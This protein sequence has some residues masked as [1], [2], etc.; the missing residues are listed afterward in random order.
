[1]SKFTGK[2]RDS[3]SGLDNFG[4]RYDSSSLGRF[5][6]V[7]PSR[8]SINPTNPQSWNRYTYTLNNPL[9]LVDQNG[10]WPTRIHDEIIE[11]VFGGVLTRH[12]V[13]LLKQVSAG[14]DSIRN[15]GPNPNNSNWHGQCTPSQSTTQC[16]AGISTYVNGNLAIAWVQADL[17]GLTD[18][19]LTYF[20]KAGHTLTDLGSPSHVAADGTPTTWYG[21][22]PWHWGGDAA[23][24][25]GERDEAIDWY[26]IGQ[27][28]RG[29][30]EPRARQ[31]VVLETG[32]L[33]SSL[34]RGRMAIHG[35]RAR[36]DSV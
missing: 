8:V 33:L 35:E 28:V 16:G 26:G 30:A 3:E 11:A 4:A 13:N 21:L 5:M 27:S 17:F 18:T 36:R 7:D 22:A 6:S 31:N 9:N 1:M 19:A 32:M 23:H 15:G 29:K 12:Q 10:L 34:T 25:F 24:V 20:G 2:E 14:Q